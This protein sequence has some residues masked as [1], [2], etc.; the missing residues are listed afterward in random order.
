MIPETLPLNVEIKH[1]QADTE[2][3]CER[4]LAVLGDRPRV[5]FSSFDWDLLAALEAHHPAAAIAPIGSRRPHE[6]LRAAESLDAATVHCHRRLAFGDFI[7]AARVSGWPVLVYTVND[8]GL[9]AALFE[10]GA[11][12]VFTDRPG[13]LRAELESA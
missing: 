10:R 5:L 4:L 9:A 13:A 7:A 11:A 12:G 3:L 1:S 2:R 8:A 6:V